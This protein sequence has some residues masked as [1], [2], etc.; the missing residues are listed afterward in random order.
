M[1]VRPG[2]LLKLLHVWTEAYELVKALQRDKNSYLPRPTCKKRA[3]S[4]KELSLCPV[5][6]YIS[7]K[8][9]QDPAKIKN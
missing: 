4:K 8:Q 7:T 6:K 2:L 5:L 9:L 1:Q 3:F